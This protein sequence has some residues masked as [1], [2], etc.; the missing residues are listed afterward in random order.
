[1]NIVNYQ[2]EQWYIVQ[3]ASNNMTYAF[4]YKNHGLIGYMAFGLTDHLETVLNS[5]SV[6]SFTYTPGTRNYDY[7]V[8]LVDKEMG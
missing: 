5:D 4:Y 8:S 1:M 2:N 7:L 6:E 3:D